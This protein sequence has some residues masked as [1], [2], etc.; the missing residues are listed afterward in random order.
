[1]SSKAK[2]KYKIDMKDVNSSVAVPWSC[3]Y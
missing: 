3:I 2:Y 1:M